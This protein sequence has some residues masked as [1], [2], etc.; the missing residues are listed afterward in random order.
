M[1]TIKY[2]KTQNLDGEDIHDVSSGTMVFAAGSE[3]RAPLRLTAGSSL[4]SPI[5]GSLEYNGRTFYTTPNSTS[6][7]AFNDAKHMYAL[8][9][10]RTLIA[11]VVAGTFYSAFGVGLN[12]EADNA[13]LV[14][15]FCGMRT[16]TTS[17]TVSFRFGGTATYSDCQFRTEFTN[18]ALSTGTAGAGTPTAPVTLQFTA[19]PNTTSTNSII[20]PASAIASKFF[21]V[22][23]IVSCSAS[24]TIFPEVAFSANPGGTNQITR[25]S[26]ITLNP[27]GTS[28]GDLIAGN[29]I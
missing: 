3:T 24:G 8:S 18:L 26:Y 28:T 22:Q 10:D 29:W 15:V 19:N 21:R 14:D 16:G 20:S 17:H 2:S 25:F 23:G 4:T 9:A 5:A 1:S 6:G 13:Y 12:V 11:T 27:I 7:K